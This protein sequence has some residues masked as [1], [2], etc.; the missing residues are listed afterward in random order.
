MRG[1]CAVATSLI[2]GTTKSL[3]P[4]PP[5]LPPP[6]FSQSFPARAK[7]PFHFH[8]LFLHSSRFIVG[9]LDLLSSAFHDHY[10]SSCLLKPEKERRDR[11]PPP[12]THTQTSAIQIQLLRKICGQASHTP[13]H[14]CT[15]AHTALLVNY[16]YS[17]NAAKLRESCLAEVTALYIFLLCK[18][19][20]LGC[21][22]CTK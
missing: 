12:P 3:S 18:A 19:F 17:G 1:L 15:A 4:L 14:A 8:Y 20:P 7:L 13:Q 2:Y 6:A 5:S 16:C 11:T 10:I 9:L 21:I 22:T